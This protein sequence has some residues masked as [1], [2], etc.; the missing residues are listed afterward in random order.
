M[1]ENIACENIEINFFWF[2]DHVTHKGTDISCKCVSV[3]VFYVFVRD[4]NKIK[5]KIYFVI[6][7]I[8]FYLKFF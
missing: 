1:R 8:I 3:E 2:Q 5:I 7:F 6:Y 4:K